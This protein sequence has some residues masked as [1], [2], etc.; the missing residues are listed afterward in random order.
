MSVMR[1][2]LIFAL[3]AVQAVLM[4]QPAAN[5]RLNGATVIPVLP[6][7]PGNPRNTE[8]SFVALRDG[9][10]LYAYTRFTGGTGDHDSASIAGRYSP[11]GGRTW[12]AEDMAIVAGEGAMNVMSVSLLRLRWPRRALLSPQKLCHRLPALH[13]LLAR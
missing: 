11:D 10:I 3:T 8:G 4:A 13:A 5:P 2:Y 6:P 1:A 12:S 9:R 7:G